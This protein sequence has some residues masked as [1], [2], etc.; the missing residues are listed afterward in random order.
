MKIHVYFFWGDRKALDVYSESGN[1]WTL[2]GF[3]ISNLV[4]SVAQRKWTRPK[5]MKP[6]VRIPVKKSGTGPHP[7]I[8][9][10]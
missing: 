9:Y 3:S 2:V 10:M 1:Y 4:V 5:T 7:L 6:R 8:K